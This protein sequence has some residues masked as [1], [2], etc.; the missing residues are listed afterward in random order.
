[1]SIW[2]KNAK[3]YIGKD[4]QLEVC[5]LAIDQEGILKIIRKDEEQSTDEQNK[6]SHVIDAE[7]LLVMPAFADLHVHFREPGFEHK[8]TL[9]TGQRAA[10]MGGVTAVCTMPNTKPAMDREERLTAYLDKIKKHPLIDVLPSV[11][12]TLDQN[13]TEITDLKGLTQLGAVAYTDDGRTVMDPNILAKALEIS[14][15]TRCPVMT[16]SEDHEKAAK[17]PNGPYPP[18]VESEIIERDTHILETTGGHLHIAHLSTIN[19]LEAVKEGKRKGMNLTCEVAPHHLYF[20]SEVLEFE[21]ATYKVNPPLR[22]EA[23]RKALLEGI[24]EGWVDAIASDH[25]PHEWESKLASYKEG[26]YGFTGL[27]TMF[28]TI[29]TLFRQEDIPMETLIKLMSINPRIILNQPLNYIEDGAVANL[30]CIDPNNAWEV[31]KEKFQSKSI[32]SP[33]VGETLTGK[34]IHVVKGNQLLLEGGQLNVI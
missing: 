17:Y 34:V 33:W 5:N 2:I 3:A 25:A 16:H 11:A 30:V 28:S 4:L 24:K 15:V 21:T 13:G 1:M 7:N 6:F 32:N 19:S 20:N 12:V 9:E 23:N 18:E 22:G 10:I 14:K 26:S 31:K 29:N 8:E 27:E